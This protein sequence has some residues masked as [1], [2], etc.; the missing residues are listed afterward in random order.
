[1]E[2]G[3]KTDGATPALPPETESA[4]LKLLADCGVL[5]TGPENVFD[6]LVKA[7][8]Y[9]CQTPILLISFV[10][11]QR[12]WFKACVGLEISETPRSSSFCSHAICQPEQ[13]FV[14]EDTHL[15]E[16]FIHHPLVVGPPHIRFY[17]GFP[18][19]TSSGLALGTLCVI[20]TKPRI[21][22]PAPTK[23]LVA[24]ALQISALLDQRTSLIEMRRRLASQSEHEA[25]LVSSISDLEH[26]NDALLAAT[27]T[28]PLTGIGNRRGFDT[29][30]MREQERALRDHQPLPVIM[31]DIDFLKATTTCSAMWKA[32]R[33]SST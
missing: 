23:M 21:L 2:L 33:Y 3:S 24:L 11:E 4:R 20:D 7:A 12:Q 17:A 16:R 32:T 13:A 18:L 6:E 5:D 15:D 8:S 31:I 10:D 26:K 25:A 29:A 30:L 9:I 22:S 19:V 14:I 27:L 28:D 1:M